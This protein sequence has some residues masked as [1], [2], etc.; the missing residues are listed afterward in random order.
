MRNNIRLN[1]YIIELIEY[2]WTLNILYCN[3]TLEDDG[4]HYEE[5][6]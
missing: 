2:Y 3:E 4:Y 5:I 1:R 6:E